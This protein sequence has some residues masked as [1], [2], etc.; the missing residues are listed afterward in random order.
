[1]YT[2]CQLRLRHSRLLTYLS[3]THS[4]PS[5]QHVIFLSFSFVYIMTPHLH[6]RSI[7]VFVYIIGKVYRVV[8]FDFACIIFHLMI[9]SEENKG[10]HP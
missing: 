6:A 10:E 2:L 7:I 4:N 3:N 5:L 9:Q 1:M 8:K